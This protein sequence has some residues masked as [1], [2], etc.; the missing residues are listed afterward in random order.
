[1]LG[2]RRLAELRIARGLSQRQLADLVGTTSNQISRWER[3]IQ[4]PRDPFKVAL[5]RVLEVP[6]VFLFPFEDLEANGDEAA[7]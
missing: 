7:A 2:P 6:A 3:G 4:R 1:M 5:A